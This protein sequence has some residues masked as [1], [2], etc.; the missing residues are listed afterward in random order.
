M[1]QVQSVIDSLIKHIRRGFEGVRDHRSSNAQYGLADILSSGFA[2]FGLKDPS[3]LAFREQY[4]MRSQN[5][6]RVYGIE[7]IPEDT[8]FRGALDGVSPK[9][10][11]EQFAIPLAYLQE[12]GVL[13][14]RL[15][16]R[17]LGG[18]SALSMDGT[19]HYGSR[20]KPCPQCLVKNLRDGEPYYYHQLL[21]GVLVHP[22]Q[23]TV[24]PLAAEAIVQQ[25][26]NTK[27]DCEQNAAKRLVPRLVE[28]LP[29]TYDKAKHKPLLL[30]DALYATG[31]SIRLA[32]EHQMNFICTIKQ[33]YVKEQ[34]KQLRT[35]G[36]L[37]EH[38]W[39]NN[40]NNAKRRC[41]LHYACQLI[42]SGVHQDLLV[43]YFEYTE[44]DTKTGKTT[45]HNTWITDLPIQMASP[46][47]LKELV[48]VARARWKVENETFNTLKNQ[49]Y[50]LEHNYGHGKC[51]LATN[52]ALLMF[53]A[54]LVDQIAQHLDQVFQ[55]AWKQCKSKRALWEKLRQVFD[56]I[57]AMSM[58]AIFKFIAKR[59]QLD[60]PLLE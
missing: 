14:D 19:G 55:Y 40:D 43:N 60:Y 41:S 25:D 24:F 50:H 53:L 35:K 54:F 49:G 48:A 33:G 20:K 32:Q 37:V 58:N 5:L 46:E 22:E 15:V 38:H 6:H 9:H 45:Y 23:K 30:L 8:A 34:V 44:V 26:G 10:L 36:R 59:K 28:A 57:P 39:F 11:Q 51:Y 13:E 31:P 42:H 17:E 16:L 18:Y 1:K 4:P 7:T 12:Q 52:F 3:L 2:M 56:L 27:N 29:D 21:A 47:T